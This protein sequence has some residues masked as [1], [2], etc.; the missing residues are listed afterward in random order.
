MPSLQTS[1]KTSFTFHSDIPSYELSRS[2]MLHATKKTLSSYS[3][4]GGN[5]NVGGE[6]EWREEHTFAWLEN[7]HHSNVDGVISH[8]VDFGFEESG[9]I[10]IP[11]SD[12]EN[13]CH[14]Y[15]HACELF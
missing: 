2:G 12:V 10:F 13:W 3:N 11:Y 7:K 14:R 5:D 15:P 9:M 1:N 8:L 4:S 6:E